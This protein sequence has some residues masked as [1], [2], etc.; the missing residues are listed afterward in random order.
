MFFVK[1][2]FLKKDE[3]DFPPIFI[4]FKPWKSDEHLLQMNLSSD[5]VSYL[6]Y[7]FAYSEILD[8]M[9]NRST[10][11]WKGK[12][13][14]DEF[15][16]KQNYTRMIDALFQWSWAFSEISIEGGDVADKNKIYFTQLKQ[17]CINVTLPPLT[18]S[19]I[20][21]SRGRYILWLV[22]PFESKKPVSIF[23]GQDPRTVSEEDLIP[24]TGGYKYDVIISITKSISL[25][26]RANPCKDDAEV[27]KDNYSEEYCELLCQERGRLQSSDN[28]AEIINDTEPMMGDDR[29]LNLICSFK[30]LFRETNPDYSN[31]TTTTDQ[32]S[33]TAVTISEENLKDIFKFCARNCPP[34][35]TRVSY[36]VQTVATE[37]I[38]DNS[39]VN[40]KFRLLDGR[41]GVLTYHE[42]EA[43]TFVSAVSNVGG[44]LGL[45]LGF[46]IVTFLQVTLYWCNDCNIKNL[47]RIRKYNDNQNEME[48]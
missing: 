30:S 40:L 9:D 35:C 4:C 6:K 29:A 24:L 39:S 16:R 14:F 17:I 22:P 13:D 19:T 31:M 1:V 5:G 32:S 26:T 8:V 44:Q 25:P 2:S 37:T 28:C 21:K 48:F 42:V 33:E 3:Y 36:D 27:A 41:N 38:E 23:A 12:R 34:A 47:K 7:L 43:Y 15:Y 10:K 18:S 46:S 45:W 11:F 20:H